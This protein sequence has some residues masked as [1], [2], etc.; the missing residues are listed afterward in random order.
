M[1]R[2]AEPPT[3]RLPDDLARSFARGSFRRVKTGSGRRQG[4]LLRV[5][6]GGSGLRLLNTGP[7]STDWGLYLWGLVG[8]A[9]R[10]SLAPS[11]SSRRS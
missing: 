7:V 2:W 10:V 11:S 5:G 1:D 3:T 6:A 9:A 8:S 4:G